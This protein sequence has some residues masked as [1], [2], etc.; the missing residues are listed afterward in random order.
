M[1]SYQQRINIIIGQLQGV[2]RMID[3]EINPCDV[4]LQIKASKQALKSFM[5]IYMQ[6]HFCDCI[7]SCKNRKERDELIKSVFNNLTS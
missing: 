5:N 3:E 2:N 4:I 6:E 7:K 1:K